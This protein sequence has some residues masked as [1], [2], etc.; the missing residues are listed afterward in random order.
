MA[1]PLNYL[2]YLNIYLSLSVEYMYK[3][4][5]NVPQAMLPAFI[6]DAEELQIR[7]LAECATKHQF[8]LDQM[9]SATS[10]SPISHSRQQPP[11]SSSTP[12]LS[13]SHSGPGGHPGGHPGSHGGSGK[14]NGS[15]G[16]T[17]NSVL[18]PGGILA[19]RLKDMTAQAGG[20]PMG[21]LLDFNPE[22]LPGMIAR[23]PQLFNAAMSGFNPGSMPGGV[24]PGGLPPLPHVTSNKKSRKSAEPRPRSGISPTKD[25]KKLKLKTSNNLPQNSGSVSTNNNYGDLDDDGGGSL[26]IDE[27]RIDGSDLGPGKE[28][29]EN[30]NMDSD[31][32]Q[33][34]IAVGDLDNSNG[35]SEEEEEPSMPGPGGENYGGVD[36]ASK[37][38]LF[39]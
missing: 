39:S 1:L 16:S 24:G 21:P 12:I 23:H 19:A 34:S 13:T 4:E 26:K 36:T 29:L 11:L 18:G 6:K 38:G 32:D 10:S 22:S 20:P 28:N 25:P 37:F 7:G 31:R 30:K 27:D 3:G 2:T 8:D 9:T 5:A 33:D 17:K 14:K 15:N 35:V